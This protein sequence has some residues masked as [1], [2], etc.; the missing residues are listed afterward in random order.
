MERIKDLSKTILRGDSVL[1]EVFKKQ[2]KAGIILSAGVD[3]KPSISHMVV[4]AKGEAVTDIEVGDII[5]NV[6]GNALYL[7]VNKKDYCKFPRHNAEIVVKP[8]NFDPE[9]EPMKPLDPKPGKV[10]MN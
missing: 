2:S 10:T 8:E 7:E 6:A 1:A 3:G 5:L 4:I 9:L